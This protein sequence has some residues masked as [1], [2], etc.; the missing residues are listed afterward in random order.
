MGTV[1]RGGVNIMKP[2][3]HRIT[4]RVNDREYRLEV[5]PNEILLNVIRDRLQLTGTK[6]GCGLGECGA[7][8][9]LVD[10]RAILSCQT[11]AVSMDGRSITTIEGLSDRGG[12]HP[13]QEAF[14]SEGAIQCGFCTPGM[15]LAAKALLDRNP[16]PTMEEIRIALRGNF[17]RC[18]GYVNIFNAVRRAADIMKG[19]ET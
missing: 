14:I 19:L 11:L 2:M 5:A 4:L 3:T 8:T 1:R 7:C 10:G 17:C 18:T 13:L 6:Y 12:L 9:V 15:I 16:D